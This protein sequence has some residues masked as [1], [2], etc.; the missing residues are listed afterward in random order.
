M[1]WRLACSAPITVAVCLSACGPN[2]I[3]PVPPQ[4]T[5]HFTLLRLHKMF[6]V[7]FK[8]KTLILQNFCHKISEIKKINLQFHDN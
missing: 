1:C 6:F 3:Q 5:T 7:L 8:W 2:T 4:L